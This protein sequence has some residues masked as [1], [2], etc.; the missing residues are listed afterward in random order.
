MTAEIFYLPTAEPYTDFCINETVFCHPNGIV[1]IST[2]DKSLTVE[3]ALF[4]LEYAR[5]ELLEQMY[6]F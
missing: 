6:D 2:Q 5:Q 1:M 3:R 4:L